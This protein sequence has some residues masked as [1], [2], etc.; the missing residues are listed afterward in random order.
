MDMHLGCPTSTPPHAVK[1]RCLPRTMRCSGGGLGVTSPS[2]MATAT[3]WLIVA[4][5][6]LAADVSDVR[7]HGVNAQVKRQDDRCGRG[8]LGHELEDL[9]LPIGDLGRPLGAAGAA[10]CG[11]VVMDALRHERVDRVQQRLEL[12]PR[13]GDAGCRS[14]DPACSRVSDIIQERASGTGR[15]AYGVLPPL[16]RPVLEVPLPSC[17]L[18]GRSRL[19]TIL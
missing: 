4:L 2:M 1:T 9:D 3:A 15:P 19:V 10:M 18:A 13:S 7:A 12:P 5:L 6:K 11:A 8:A 14:R 17:P 16:G